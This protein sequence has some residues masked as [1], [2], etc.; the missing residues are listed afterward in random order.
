MT[1]QYEM[2]LVLATMLLHWKLPLVSER[3]IRQGATFMPQGGVPLQIE[4]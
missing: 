3:P 4:G 2:K 1:A